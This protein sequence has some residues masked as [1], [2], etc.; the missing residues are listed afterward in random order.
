M[1]R[2]GAKAT[3]KKSALP[4]HMGVPLANQSHQRLICGSESEFVSYLRSL[5][6]SRMDLFS[7]ALRQR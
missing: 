1:K 7:D 2:F 5:N 3:L 6:K 4:R